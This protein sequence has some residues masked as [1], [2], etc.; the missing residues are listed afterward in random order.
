MGSVH[1]RN[2]VAVAAVVSLLAALL[3]GFNARAGETV[4]GV[5]VQSDHTCEE[6]DKPEGEGVDGESIEQI[7]GDVPR[8]HQVAGGRAELGYNCGLSL[9]GHTRLNAKLDPSNPDP[10]APRRTES[11]NGNMAWSGDCAYVAG[12]GAVFGNPTPN[13]RNGVA[14]VDVTDP[15]NPVHVRTLTTRGSASAMET[16]HAVDTGDRS[17]LAV[18]EYGNQAQGPKPVD[19]YDV[20][21]CADPKLVETH[22]FPENVHNVTISGNGE[23]LYATQPTQVVDLKP[24]FAPDRPAGLVCDAE[25]P[26]GATERDKWCARYVGNLDA[27]MPGPPV[28]HGP[29]ATLDDPVQDVAWSKTNP[30]YVAHEVWPSEDGMTLYLGGQLATWETITIADITEWVRG[31]AV[32]LVGQR[33]GRGHSVRTAT[34]RN[35]D[36]SVKNELLLHS[37]ESVFGPTY[38]CISEEANPFVG[39][40]QPWLTDITDP[41][42]PETVSQFGLAIND[43]L[44]CP[45]NRDSGVRTGTHYHDFDDPD[46]ATFAMVSM[47]NAGIRLFDIRDAA[48]PVEVGYF[49]PGIVTVE[50][51]PEREDDDTKRLDHAWGH[52]RYRPETGQIWFATSSGGFWVVELGPSLRKRLDLPAPDVEPTDGK[53]KK[54]KKDRDTT[55][56]SSYV[57]HPNGRP[58]T[59]GAVRGPAD[60][61]LLPA[62]FSTLKTTAR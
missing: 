6:L 24:L 42:N 50:N 1:R 56:Q 17:I 62:D 47:W 32:R 52:V 4:T 41:T 61:P 54:E 18:G 35:D 28:A 3:A 45:A 8:S 14:V 9:V 15:A 43:P 2:R 51:D 27:A 34:V 57:R 36:G 13:P 5:W 16:L 55:S 21:N 53:V 10:A 40:A 38:G 33:E 25:T 26:A 59:D 60:A 37:E 49:N 7:Q 23:W 31:G 48:K 11:G 29:T 12:S 44:N 30:G 58:G 20:S 39:P 46:D 22:W 19:I